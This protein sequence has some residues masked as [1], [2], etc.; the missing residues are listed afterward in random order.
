MN[1]KREAELRRLQDQLLARITTAEDQAE[2]AVAGCERLRAQRD[3]LLEALELL[4]SYTES[5]EGLLNASPA[6]QV[7]KARAAIKMAE[8][9]WKAAAQE[10]QKHFDAELKRYEGEK[11]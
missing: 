10:A 3:A 7:L 8:W 11:E 1:E 5:C 2:R 9:D 4:V 6:G